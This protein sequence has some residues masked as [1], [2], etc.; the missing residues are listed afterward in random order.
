MPLPRFQRLDPDKRAQLLSI[1]SREFA[2]RGY[3]AASLNDI[4]AA[5][6]LGKSSYYYYFADK[7]DLYATVI[8]DAFARVTAQ[9]AAPDLTALDAGT[10][11]P[12]LEAYTAAMSAAVSRTP[13]FVTLFR[14]LQGL[15]RNPTERFQPIVEAMRAHYRAGIDV[16]RRLGCVRSDLEVDLLISMLQA[17]DAALD[18]HLMNQWEIDPEALRQHGRLAFDSIRRLLEPRP[19]P[20]QRPTRTLRVVRSLDQQRF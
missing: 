6:G 3:E 20:V 19:T 11:W 15:W 1:A 13:D 17:V 9:V 16:G 7:E 4:L 2:E 10:F 8:E 5:A 14:P 12:A 18:E